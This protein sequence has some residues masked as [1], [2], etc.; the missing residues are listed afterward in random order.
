MPNFNYIALNQNGKKIKGIYNASSLSDVIEMLRGKKYVPVEINEKKS[1]SRDLTIFDSFSRV[2]IKDL[3]VFCRQ[4]QVML[5]AGVP[6]VNSLDILKLQTEKKKFKE[7]IEDLYEQVQ[8]GSTFSEA[9]LNHKNV[10]PEI[11][12]NMVEAGEVSGNLDIIMERLSVHFEKEFKIENK[13]KGA[14][15][16]PIILVVAVVAVVSFLLV[17]VMPTF[18]GMFEGS[19]VELPFLTQVLL[20][21]SKFL[22]TRWYIVLGIIASIVLI[23][24]RLMQEK[25]LRIKRDK[26]KLKLPIIKNVQ[27]KV[28]SS[29]FTRTL[30]TLMSSGVEL[31]KSI[32]IVSRVTG[33]EYIATTLIEIKEDLRKGGTLS[34]PL[35]RRGIFPPMIPAMVN[36]GEESGAIDEVLDKT[37]NFYDEEVDV[38]INKMTTI[39]EPLMIVI[40]AV[41]VGFVVIAMILPMF[42]MLKTIN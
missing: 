16:Y 27:I 3:A 22:R 12:I 10:F 23:Y 24:K 34:E 41:I 37:A 8:K 38:A 42:D 1:K 18:L 26:F 11:M 33:N 4:F 28:A 6:I 40:M 15:I 21:I 39:L 29:R 14:M 13:V 31:M 36:I 32:E 35:K 9:L 20:S 2:T 17:F 7:I 25:N 5:N 19:G 30:S